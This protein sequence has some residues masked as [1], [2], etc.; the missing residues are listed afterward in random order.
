MKKPEPDADVWGKEGVLEKSLDAAEAQP[1][2]KSLHES[3][4]GIMPILGLGD[5]SIAASDDDIILGIECITDGQMKVMG[6]SASCMAAVFLNANPHR[7][8]TMH[9]LERGFR[10]RER[11]RE[12]EREGFAMLRH[13]IAPYRLMHVTW[14]PNPSILLSQRPLVQAST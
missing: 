7:P 4:L 13:F 10:E 14:D 2:A 1:A 11:Q 6:R 12:R 5:G 3:D 8:I 9:P